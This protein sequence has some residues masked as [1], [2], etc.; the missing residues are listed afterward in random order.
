MRETEQQISG[1]LLSVY[2]HTFPRFPDVPVKASAVAT[3]LAT[4]NAS[5]SAFGRPI[6]RRPC[7]HF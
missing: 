6:P 3:F 4:G 5:G 2:D 7:P 1:T